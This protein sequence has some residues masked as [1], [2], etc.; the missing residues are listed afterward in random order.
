MILFDE[1]QT[2]PLPLVVAT[3]ATLSRL[4]DP[5][6]PYRSTVVFATATQPAFEVLDDRVR[7]EFA[8]AGWRPKE[9]VTNAG[10]LYAAAARRVGVTWRHADAIALEDLAVELQGHGRV[11]CV[12]NLK[13]HAVQ[14]ATL[15]RD[16]EVK[17]LFH[18]STNMCPA[19]RKEVLAEVNR[20]LGSG[21]KVRL[22]ATQCVEAGVD[23]DFPVVYRALGPLEAIAQAAGRCNRHGLGPVG[24]VVVFKPH[25]DR[26][27]YP[28]GYREA[29]DATGIYLAG[30]AEQGDLDATEVLNDPERLGAYFRQFYGLSGRAASERDD[31]HSLLEAIR[32][33]D[34][35]EVA[36]LYRL[37]KQDAVSVL[38]PFDRPKFD[39]LRAEIADSDRLRPGFLRDWLRRAAPHAVSLFRPRPGD[40]IW[41]LLDPVQF[42]RHHPLDTNQGDWFIA[43]PGLEYDQLFGVSMRTDSLWIA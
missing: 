3:L 18:L 35:P 29:V 22:V 40:S 2:L 30:L 34:F 32:A 11:L 20:R 16:R 25:D 10:P 24:R 37:I 13:R 15:L 27:L 39:R 38:V 7:R 41:N 1:V 6:G 5:A 23:L 26:G 31:E 14:L 28:P 8:S 42:G 9:I 19:H 33:G 4:A 17:G 43:L 12:V 36:K 21:R